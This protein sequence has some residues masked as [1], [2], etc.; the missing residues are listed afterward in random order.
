MITFPTYQPALFFYSGSA[1]GAICV[2]TIYAPCGCASGSV[3][4]GDCIL[5]LSQS[6]DFCCDD[7][8]ALSFIGDYLVASSADMICFGG[9]TSG[10]FDYNGHTYTVTL[11]PSQVCTSIGEDCCP[12]YD[13]TLTV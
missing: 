1:P 3:A 13:I 2:G 11:N 12:L 10:S 8:S 6:C 5:P 4:G 9:I 7:L